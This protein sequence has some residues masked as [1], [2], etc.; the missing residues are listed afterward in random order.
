[1]P[2]TKKTK[3]TYRCPGCFRLDNDSSFLFYDKKKKEYYCT[4]C[5]FSGSEK[6]VKKGYEATEV[7]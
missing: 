6:V 4:R 3:V 1:M 5:F 2:G 7:A